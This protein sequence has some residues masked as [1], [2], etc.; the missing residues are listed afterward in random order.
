MHT[1]VGSDQT[2]AA[3]ISKSCSKHGRIFTDLFNGHNFIALHDHE[4]NHF[5]RYSGW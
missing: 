2:V 5:V 4:Q 1:D 3:R